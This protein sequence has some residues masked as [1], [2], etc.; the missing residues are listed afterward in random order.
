MK[1]TETKYLFLLQALKCRPLAT[2]ADLGERLD[3]PPS[4][5]NR[6]VKRLAAWNAIEIS[7][8]ERRRYDLTRKGRTLLDRASWAF[9]ASGAGLLEQLRGRAIA[10]LSRHAPGRA[11]LYGATPIAN[12]LE[13]WARDA[14]LEIAAVCDE[15]R[16]GR[17][18]VRLDDLRAL[19][20]DMIVLADWDR[21]DDAMLARLLN[22]F[23]TVIN[24]FKADGAARPEWR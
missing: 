11:V 24:L 2:H 16:S 10:E 6:Y 14:G 23:G 13:R 17:D 8:R 19:D 21:A 18:V 1:A 5:V 7:D 15:E 4:L 9:L 22:E 3:I 20:Y 12:V